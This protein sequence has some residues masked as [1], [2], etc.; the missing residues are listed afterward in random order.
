MA[1]VRQE[2]AL[3]GIGGFGRFETAL[4][5][6]V[7]LLQPD[8]QTTC[9]DIQQARSYRDQAESQFQEKFT[10]AKQSHCPPDGLSALPN[11]A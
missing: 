6:T 4:Q 9:P 7:L 10:G 3:S 1:H 8:F 2:I 5:V 11:K